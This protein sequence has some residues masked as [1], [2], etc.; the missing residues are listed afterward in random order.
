MLFNFSSHFLAS[1]CQCKTQSKITC[2]LRDVPLNL[3]SS[4]HAGRLGPFRSLWPC[5]SSGLK[6]LKKQR[7]RKMVLVFLSDATTGNAV[8]KHTLVRFWNRLPRE[9]VEAPSL[10]AFEVRLD[11]VLSNSI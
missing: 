4:L 6:A 5:I 8:L 1:I 10:E 3:L 2:I 9:V 7:V 11:R